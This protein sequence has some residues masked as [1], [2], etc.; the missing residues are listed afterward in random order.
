[1]P[2]CVHAAHRQLRELVIKSVRPKYV[3]SKLYSVIMFEY[4]K[5]L[6]ICVENAQAD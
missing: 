5:S 4:G 6:N 3:I 2:A 1:M